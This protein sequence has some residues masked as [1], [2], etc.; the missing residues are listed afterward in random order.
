[1]HGNRLKSDLEYNLRSAAEFTRLIELF[2]NDPDYV[3]WLQTKVDRYQRR[4]RILEAAY[5]V[6]PSRRLDYLATQR[7]YD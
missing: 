7:Y 3:T 5:E 4:A 1:M 6:P 2:G